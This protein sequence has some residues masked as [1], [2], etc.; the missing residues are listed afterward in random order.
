VDGFGHGSTACKDFASH[1]FEFGGTTVYVVG[2]AA[3]FWP[4][5]RALIVADLHLEKA[6]SYA[7]RGQML[8]PYDSLATLDMIT[9]LA[10]QCNAAAV[11]CMGDNFH[12]DA[13]ETRLQGKAAALLREMTQRYDWTWITGNHDPG[14]A[15]TW[16]GTV[17]IERLVE[18]IMLRHEAEPVWPGPEIS[19]HFHPKLRMSV[20]KRN[21]SRRAFVM[22]G[23]KLIMPAFGALTGGMDA[24]DPA[25]LRAVGGDPAEALVPLKDRLSRFALSSAS[26]AK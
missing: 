16:G 2:E 1:I 5:Q 19:G 26:F 6:S 24:G 3:L 22:T 4:T 20:R 14:V 25:I 17:A 9:A 12:D 11:I 8:P 23:R 15:A 7:T 10:E 13:G 18:G 21:V